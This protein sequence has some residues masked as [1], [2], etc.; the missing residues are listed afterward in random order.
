MYSIYKMENNSLINEKN[1]VETILQLMEKAEQFLDK[2]GIE[3]KK[4]VLSNLQS[5]MGI[6][7]Y[8]RYKHFISSIVEFVIELSKG[9]K[10]V[11]INNIKKKF[12]CLNIK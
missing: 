8:N 11:N 1:I 4:L 12:C 2:T 9:N 6:D 5:L 3:K 10:K 7:I